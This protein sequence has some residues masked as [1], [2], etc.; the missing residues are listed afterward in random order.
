MT[1][2]PGGLI[3]PPKARPGDRIAVLSP[4]FAAPGAFPAVH[5]RAM[6]RRL[7]E[8]TGLVPV[9]YPTTRE[10]GAAPRARAAEINAALADPAIRGI[11]AIIGCADQ[12]S[13]SRPSRGSAQVR[14]GTFGHG[15]DLGA[16]SRSS[17][18]SS[19]RDDSRPVQTSSTAACSSSKPQKNSPRAQRGWIVRSLGERG[20]LAAGDAVLVARPPTSDLARRTAAW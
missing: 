7:T 8:V 15:P 10:V 6:R 3:H 14:P 19:P 20:N 5:E 11:L 12:I 16:A 9:E 13:A 4:S 1:R 2:M 18:G 17:I